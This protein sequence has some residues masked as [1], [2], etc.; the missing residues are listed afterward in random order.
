MGFEPS[1][2]ILRLYKYLNTVNT[3]FHKNR[4]SSENKRNLVLLS[5]YF[6]GKIF[7]LLFFKNHCCFV[8]GCEKASINMD[9]QSSAFRLQVRG[10][11]SSVYFKMNFRRTRYQMFKEQE[12]KGR[13]GGERKTEKREEE[14]RGR[15]VT[16]SLS[17]LRRAFVLT[18]G[19][20]RPFP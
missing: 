10:Q 17:K 5:Y 7:L 18:L 19:H 8:C 14:G 11:K 9:P 20:G 3:S 4:K 6:Y 16:V 12:N 15:R 2:Y 13:K 1:R